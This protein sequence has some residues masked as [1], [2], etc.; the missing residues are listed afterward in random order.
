MHSEKVTRLGRLLSIPLL[1]G[2]GGCFSL[3]RGEPMQQHFVLGGAAQQENA[4]VPRDLAGLAI[5]MRRL[6]IAPYLETPLIV[7]R[8]GPHQIGFSE[9][10]RWGERLEGGINQ[11]VASYLST[12]AAFRGVDVAPWPVRERYD[13]IIQ[14]HVLRFEGMAPEDE[15]ATRGEAHLLATWE[16]LHQDGSVLARGTTDYR[17]R[18]WRVGDFPGLVASL[19]NGLSELSDDLM[20]SIVGLGAPLAERR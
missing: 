14:L 9:F 16:I 5:G 12:R 20:R 18:D 10:H 6:Q 19:D 13:Y 2:L 17:D 11:A 7:V 1:I 8:R 15:A 4:A 3:G